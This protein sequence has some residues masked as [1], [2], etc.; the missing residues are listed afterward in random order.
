MEEINLN[1]RYRFPRVKFRNGETKYGM[2]YGIYN[3]ALNKLEYFFASSS[4]IRKANVE[5]LEVRYNWVRKL[6]N[7]V[8]MRDII[9]IEYLN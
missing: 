3:K 7:R 9:H 6:Q 8:N 2:V 5:H 4:D 1:Y